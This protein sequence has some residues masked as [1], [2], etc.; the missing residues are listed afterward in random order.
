MYSNRS[1][2]AIAIPALAFALCIGGVQADV[3]PA[4]WREQASETAWAEQIRPAFFGDRDI[5]EGSGQDLIELKAPFRA[6]DAA[7]VPISIHVRSPQAA[8]KYVRKIHVFIDKNPVPLV[9]MFTLTPDSGRADLAMRVRVDDFSFIR[10]IAET[11]D[12]DLYLTKSFVRASGA[13]SAPPPRSID[14]SIANMGSMKMKTVGQVE[15]GKPS[16]VQLMIKHPNITGLQPMEIGSRVLPPAHFLS[17]V[18]VNFA[19]TPI[20]SADL[21]F[22]ISMDPSLRFFFVP[23]AKGTLTVEATDTQNNRWVSTHEVGE[24]G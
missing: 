16:L 24:Q 10:A 9:G 14:D 17:Q 3:A 11:S 15:I 21:T 4:D 8:G 2:C 1:W 6:E 23:K 13:C 7:V 22:S 5:T 12:G 19:G 18:K 20:M